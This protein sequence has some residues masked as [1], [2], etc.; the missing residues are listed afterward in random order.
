MKSVRSGYLAASYGAH[1]D[2]Q[3]AV[4]RLEPGQSLQIQQK[5]IP[6]GAMSG[7]V[8]D[9]DGEPIERVHIIVARR[10][11]EYGKPRIEGIESTN[12]DDQGYYRVGSLA[13]G[14][15]YVI[16]EPRSMQWNAV[17]RTPQSSAAASARRVTFYPGSP[18]S[19]TATVIPLAA[20][21]RVNGIDITLIRSRAY[22]VTGRVVKASGRLN[23]TLLSLTERGLRDL[24]PQTLTRNGEGDFEFSA[25]PPGGSIW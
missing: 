18:D 7:V 23:V 6:A 4:I 13:P 5:L 24:E 25:V 9:S 11:A 22:R 20:G 2:R 3:G 16:A 21:A 17:D 15:Y 14:K 10:T 1:S 8:R 12:T 19:A